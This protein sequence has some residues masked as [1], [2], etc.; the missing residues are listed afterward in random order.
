MI[1]VDTNVLARYLLQDDEAQWALASQLLSA[2]RIYVPASVV[3]ELVWLLE[4][5]YKIPIPEVRAAIWGLLDTASIE[6]EAEDKIRRALNYHEKGVD[7]ADALHLATSQTCQSLATFD[8]AFIKAAATL[9]S[10]IPVTQP[11]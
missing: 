1:S 10:S 2:S 4:K 6:V 5:R 3:L 9:Q 8:Q 11:Q 7:F